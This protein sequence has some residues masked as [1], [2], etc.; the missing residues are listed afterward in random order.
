VEMLDK[1]QKQALDKGGDER[2]YST[3]LVLIHPCNVHQIKSTPCCTSG[4]DT[5]YKNHLIIYFL[6]I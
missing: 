4:I 2:A 6:I 3:T 1:D 5:M